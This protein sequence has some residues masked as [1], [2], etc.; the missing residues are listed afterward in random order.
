MRIDMPFSLSMCLS[1]FLL[2]VYL[3][4]SY[5]EMV[6]LLI[7]PRSTLLKALPVLEVPFLR[8]QVERVAL[9][10]L[11][12]LPLPLVQ[13]PH[14][15]L[16]VFLVSRVAK[17]IVLLILHLLPVASLLPLSVMQLPSAR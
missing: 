2:E 8:C 15:L 5:V 12:C 14:H 13:L 9:A 3:V 6:G 17:S 1:F 10:K 16:E 11:P 4:P 7:L